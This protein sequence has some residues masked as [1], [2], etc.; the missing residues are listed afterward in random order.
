MM[1]LILQSLYS[2]VLQK[3]SYALIALGLALVFGR[4]KVINLA[5]GELV[6]LAAY[7]AYAVES[8]LNISPIY[9]IPIALVIVCLCSV[10]VYGLVKMIWADREL[11]S[12][13][14]T[15]GIGVILTNAILL[16]W[17]A[18]VHSTSSSWLQ[19]AIVVG[20]LFSMRGE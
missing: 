18:D 4:M 9:A 5:H 16:I 3:K 13:I 10:A 1:E 19:E 6:L 17:S 12:L 11:N 15:Y 8:G 2:G 7:I 20:P 14:L